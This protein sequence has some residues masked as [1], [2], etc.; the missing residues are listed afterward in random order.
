MARHLARAL[1]R[2]VALGAVIRTRDTP[3]QVGTATVATRASNV[4]GAFAVPFPAA[5]R[6]GRILLVDDVWTSGA[7]ARAVA[8][9]LREAGAATV[10]VVTIARVL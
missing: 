1:D 4:A 7:T 3:S 6:G 8:R 5:L 9:V 10:D 2:P